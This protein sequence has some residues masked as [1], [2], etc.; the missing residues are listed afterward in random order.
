[1]RCCCR[2]RACKAAEPCYIRPV[3]ASIHDACPKALV[4]CFVMCGRLSGL[5]VLFL[6]L[7]S[8]RMFYFQCVFRVLILLSSPVSVCRVNLARPRAPIAST[9]LLV[10]GRETHSACRC[11]LRSVRL[12]RCLCCCCLT[13]RNPGS[14]LSMDQ[15]RSLHYR[16]FCWQRE[17]RRPGQQGAFVASSTSIACLYDR[18][19]VVGF[20]S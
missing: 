4:V 17:H 9:A 11:S 7:S 10:L 3:S 20:C 8:Q 12:P 1:L 6:K 19:A 14:V 15:R 16:L 2:P 5:R 13:V 18:S